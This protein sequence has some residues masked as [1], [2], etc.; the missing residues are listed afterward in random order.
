MLV[1]EEEWAEGCSI[2]YKTNCVHRRP[3]STQNQTKPKTNSNLIKGLVVG[4]VAGEGELSHQKQDFEYGRHQRSCRRNIPILI[5][6]AP[7]D[8]LAGKHHINTSIFISRGRSQIVDVSAWTLFQQSTGSKV[9]RGSGAAATGLQPP[10]QSVPCCVPPFPLR[11]FRPLPSAFVLTG[12]SMEGR[13]HSSWY[14]WGGQ[15]SL[16]SGFLAPKGRKSLNV[17]GGGRGRLSLCGTLILTT[18]KRLLLTKGS[19]KVL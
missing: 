1:G 10:Q 19:L 7:W 15:S 18:K 9:L 2:C 8:S 4:G 3:H 13:E 17:I 12:Y 6:K 16:P 14:F 11:K 5:Y